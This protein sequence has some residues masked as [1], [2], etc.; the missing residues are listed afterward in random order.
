MWTGVH[1]VRVGTI[2]KVRC[3]LCLGSVTSL[4]TWFDRLRHS[5]AAR[6][7]VVGEYLQSVDWGTLRH[8]GYDSLGPMQTVLRFDDVVRWD[9]V[10]L[11]ASL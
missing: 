3:K 11:T 9:L 8:G 5:D 2:R 6:V 7:P 4:V 10:A 1:Y